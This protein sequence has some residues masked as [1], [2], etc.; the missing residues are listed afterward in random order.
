MVF[1]Y[2]YWGKMQDLTI[3]IPQACETS[4]NNYMGLAYKT[5]L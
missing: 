1:S 4:S 5:V 3:F 2:D